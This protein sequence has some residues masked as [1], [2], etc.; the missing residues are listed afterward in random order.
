ILSDGTFKEIELLKNSEDDES[1]KEK[2]KLPPYLKANE[3][4]KAVVKSVNDKDKYVLVSLPGAEGLIDFETMQWARRPNPE[5]RHDKDLIKKPSDALKAGDVILVK[6]VSE[7]VDNIIK[8]ESNK[9]NQKPQTKFG[10]L[11]VSPFIAVELDQ[12][13]AVEGALL[14]FDQSTQ[15]VL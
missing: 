14:S 2:P 8:P 10:A 13:P 12:E 5:T 3:T 15:D 4:F 7:K 6:V 11:D 1:L 9:R